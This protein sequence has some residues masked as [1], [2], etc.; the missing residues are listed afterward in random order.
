M[1]KKLTFSSSQLLTF[2]VF[3]R[4]PDF[5]TIS[6]MSKDVYKYLYGL[7]KYGILLGLDNI[8]HI[9]SLLD[10]P[11]KKFPSVH[12]VGT[13]GKG[14]TAA[15]LNAVLTGAGYKTGVYTSPHLIK[16]A[17]RIKAGNKMIKESDIERIAVL[18]RGRINDSPYKDRPFTF[19]EVT[20]AM[21]FY[22]FWEQDVDIAVIEAGM[23]GRLDATNVLTPLVTIITNIGLDH[24][25]FLG[26]TLPEIAFEKASVIKKNTP[27]ITGAK[28]KE[29]LRVIE[30]MAR[31]KKAPLYMLGEDFKYEEKSL[32]E[33]EYTGING[34]LQN[35][36]VNNLLGLNQFENASLAISAL[37]LLPERG[38]DV[39]EKD[40]KSGIAGAR[41][42]G[43]FEIIRKEPPFIIDGAHNPHGIKAL[44]KNLK[45]F[46]PAGKFVFI[47]NVLKDKDI[48]D[49]INELDSLALKFILVPNRNERSY[50]QREYR[51]KF[52]SRKKFGF[53][54]DIPA[55]AG[56]AFK[57]NAPV[58]FTG[59]LYGIGEAKEFL[60]K[61]RR[62]S[63]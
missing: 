6:A 30:D 33:F 15:F 5:I 10:N 45:R 4:A 27:C 29:V 62:K 20:T 52:G 25:E 23:G 26:D 44:V 19:F 34:N 59:S 32:T 46:Y 36:R 7:E 28:G 40:I 21:C 16:F 61:W 17:E 48:N 24:R 42:E 12:I 14:S 38:F 43:R 56:N 60:K 57:E 50:S 8:R 31:K 18:I 53:A 54:S 22:Y 41:W 35:I 58:V 55:A 11:E 37:E 3:L 13:N 49:M 9:L 2:E 51:E 39:S 1:R 63:S 47:L